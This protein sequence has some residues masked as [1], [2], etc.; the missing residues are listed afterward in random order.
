MASHTN[1]SATT[2]DP[3]WLD[4]QYNNRALVPDFAHH[5]TA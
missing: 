2:P 4:A 5:L 3:T 1:T